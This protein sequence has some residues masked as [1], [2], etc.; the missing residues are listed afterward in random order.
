M[1][2]AAQCLLEKTGEPVAEN[3]MAQ[4]PALLALPGLP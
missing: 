1:S 2:G 3:E 4:L